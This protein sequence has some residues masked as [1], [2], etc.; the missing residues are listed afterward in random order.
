MFRRN[1]NT[2]IADSDLDFVANLFCRDGYPA[3]FWSVL[4]CVPCE[5]CQYLN[6][7]VFVGEDMRKARSQI[8]IQ[9]DA[10]RFRV[11]RESL[12]DSSRECRNIQRSNIQLISA[13]FDTAEF[14]QVIHEAIEA[15][16]LGVN[17]LKSFIVGGEKLTNPILG[18]LSDDIGGCTEFVTYIA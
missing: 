3:T 6:S 9:R 15:I 1:S 13:G 12:G 4:Q 14:L 5:I 8:E 10:F 2:S 18:L 11:R 16:C 17:L 7:A